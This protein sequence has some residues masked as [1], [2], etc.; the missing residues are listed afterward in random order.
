MSA[1]LGRTDQKK[2]S[3]SRLDLRS[4]HWHLEC[5]LGTMRIQLQA[6]LLCLQC[7][8]AQEQSQSICND[9]RS[10]SLR[11]RARR[12]HRADDSEGSPRTAPPTPAPPPKICQAHASCK[13]PI[14]QRADDDEDEPLRPREAQGS[15]N[16]AHHG[17]GA[18]AEAAAATAARARNLRCHTRGGPGLSKTDEPARPSSRPIRS[19]TA[20]ARFDMV[21]MQPAEAAEAAL[22]CGTGTPCKGGLPLAFERL[23]A[24]LLGEESDFAPRSA[25][26]KSLLTQL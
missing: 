3:H 10:E 20:S 24:Q 17:R 19:A 22:A 1:N 18:L 4:W 7:P 23:L 11:P 5:C 26:E 2:D 9:L 6:A 14:G 16:S 21:S 25:S 8:R 13:L 12:G 15:G